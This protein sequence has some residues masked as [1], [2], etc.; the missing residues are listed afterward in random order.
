MTIAAIKRPAFGCGVGLAFSCDIRLFTRNASLS[1]SEVKLGLYAATTSNYVLR[2]W[3]ITFTREAILSARAVTP[4]ELT[5][6][7]VVTAIAEDQAQLQVHINRLLTQ[8]KAAS[9]NT[10]RMSKELVRLTWAHR[11]EE[12]Q[13]SGIKGFF[14]Q[15]MRSDADGAHGVS[16]RPRER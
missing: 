11:G 8:L 13:A 7:G 3:A 1:L 12:R 14:K 15:M 4:G 6:I 2:E 16:S 10:L 5:A 9:P